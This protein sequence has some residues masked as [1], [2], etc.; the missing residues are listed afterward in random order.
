MISISSICNLL[1][2]KINKDF[3][4]MF[5]TFSLQQ[6]GELWCL[7]NVLR[8]QDCIHKKIPDG[9]DKYSHAVYNGS[10]ILLKYLQYIGFYTQQSYLYAFYIFLMFKNRILKR[11]QYGICPD[12]SASPFS[13]YFLIR[14]F[15]SYEKT[16]CNQTRFKMSF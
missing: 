4:T 11:I 1:R 15:A 3:L 10:F 7:F 13:I 8:G 16:K 12:M 14:E 6:F 9:T 2:F 5:L